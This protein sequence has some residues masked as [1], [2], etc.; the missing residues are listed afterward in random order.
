MENHDRD[1]KTFAC[2]LC[3]KETYRGCFTLGR[4]PRFCSNACRQKWYR[5]QR[6]IDVIMGRTPSRPVAK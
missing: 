2:K 5:L 1:S 6:K 3:G 4:K